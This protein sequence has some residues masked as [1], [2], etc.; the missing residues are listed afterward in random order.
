M[1]EFLKKFG[2][3]V[4]KQFNIIKDL[5]IDV[6]NYGA[7]CAIFNSKEDLNLSDFWKGTVWEYYAD[8]YE[9]LENNGLVAEIGDKIVFFDPNMYSAYVEYIAQKSFGMY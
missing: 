8:I 7:F 4:Q 2:S 9:E 3:E 6:E 1:R 5:S